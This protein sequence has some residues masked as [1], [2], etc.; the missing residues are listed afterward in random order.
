MFREYFEK[1]Y[2]RLILIYADFHIHTV[3]SNDSTI[4]PK[5]LVNQ[6]V[7]H[8]FV[9]AVAIT[10]HD[11][12]KGLK[13]T[14]KLAS[15]YPDILIIPG[16]EISTNQGD[17]LIL[18]TTE[19]PKKPW[20]IEAIIDFTHSV[21]GVS[22]VAHPYREYGIGD[23]AKDY[24][25][26][27]V[28]VVNGESCLDANSQAQKLAKTMKVPGIAGSDAH[29]PTEICSVYTEVRAS[30]DIEEILKSIKKGSVSIPAKVNSN[31]NIRF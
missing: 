11:T 17:I 12:I 16:V 2:E 24:K 15:P 6:L 18:G 4:T 26:D 7:S 31:K 10:D 29:S 25:F 19:I 22:I 8:N 20:T 5:N 27:A 3:Y 23:L 9:K 14:I 21:G 1:T 28:E 30:L 13:K